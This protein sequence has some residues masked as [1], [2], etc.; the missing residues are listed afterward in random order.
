M[1]VFSE[2]NVGKKRENNED[3]MLTY[4]LSDT[5]GIYMV[6]DG[7]GGANSGEVASSLAA[8]KTIEYAK[9]HFNEGKTNIEPLKMSVKYANRCVYE[10]NKQD[11]A[12]KDM[13]TTI[14]L[15]YKEGENGYIINIGD[16]RIYEVHNDRIEQLTEDDTYVNALVRDKIISKEDAKTHPER[17]VLIK[18]VGV[19]RTITFDLKE[20]GKITGRRFL[21]CSDGLTNMVQEDAIAE[22]IHKNENNKDKIC[23]ELVDV[24][25][26]NGGTDNITVMYIE[27]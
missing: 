7:I 9:E 17:H 15:L 12:Y 2:T 1:K 13:G 3:Y 24:A 19:T 10:K 16:S 14:S 27:F 11:K 23:K 20:L 6:L 18:A 25:N 22:I 8:N 21:L 4:N 26:S 5:M